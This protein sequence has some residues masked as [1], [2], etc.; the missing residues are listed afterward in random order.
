MAE[1]LR[2]IVKNAFKEKLAA[3]HV[4]STMTVRMVGG[5]EIAR[6]AKSCGF[7]AMYLD[8]QHSVT[9]L[10]TV[11]QI[12]VAAL[13]A[14]ITTIVRVPTYGPEYVL[15]VLDGG[16]MGIL[17]PHVESAADA[18]HIVKQCRFPPFGERSTGGGLPQ[19]QY[20][21]YPQ[22]ELFEVLNEMTTVMV[23]IETPEGLERVEEIAAVKG[24][25]AFMVGANDLCAG[26]GIPGQ[27]GHKLVR[28]AYARVIEVAD[29]HG[30][31]VG[32]GG[33]SDRKLI[34][35]YVKLGARIVATGTDLGILMEAGAE[36]A[37]FVQGL[38]V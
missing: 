33:I 35:E 14:G 16:A 25:D 18:E 24:I 12:C 26:L 6:I 29:K 4:A 30:K 31:Y 8:L 2:N 17:A 1:P 22:A 23:Q 38:P 5:V 20:R 3:G 27:H 19:L 7:D 21:N 36:R 34:A 10:E 11:G 32:I 9:S 13:D 37:R 15:R 28:D